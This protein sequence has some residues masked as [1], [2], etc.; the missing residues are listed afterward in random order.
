M[1]YIEALSCGTP[2]VGWGP[3][4]QEIEH[5]LG[6]KCGEPVIAGD[7]EEVVSAARR[8]EQFDWDRSALRN[9]ALRAFQPERVADRYARHLWAVVSQRG[10]SA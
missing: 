10:T 5:L 6:I 2:I 7:V 3:N 9:A 8:V 4:L 1:S